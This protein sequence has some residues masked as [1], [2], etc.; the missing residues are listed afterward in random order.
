ME[1]ILI[2]DDDPRLRVMLGE[3]L[4][5]AGLA[6]HV[7]SDAEA[8]LRLAEE[9]GT[10]LV[11]LDVMMPKVDGL[12]VLRKLRA[13]P[14]TA[15]LPVILL[16]ARSQIGDKLAGLELGADDY[17][18]KPFD[19]AELLARIRAQLRLRRLRAEVEERNEELIRFAAA[20]A[21]EV[22]APLNELALQLDAAVADSTG[23]PKALEALA[24]GEAALRRTSDVLDA[25]LQVARAGHVPEP[26]ERVELGDALRDAEEQVRVAMGSPS[27]TPVVEG[28]TPSV[29]GN[30]T[31][32][33]ELFRNLLENSVKHGGHEV[34]VIVRFGRSE[35]GL[36][37]DV[38]DDGP[39]IPPSLLP[40]LF[41]PFRSGGGGS[42]LGL[43]IARRIARGH[44]GD[45]RHEP[46]P[47]GSRFRHTLPGA[48]S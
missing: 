10:S 16:T 21:H 40:A 19:P 14:A 39:G 3:Q 20:V 6:S 28:T 38:D 26:R 7:A 42:G 18:T 31:L 9:P 22:R 35:Q 45:L 33:R 25:H 30:P 43:A 12:A 5:L 8:A 32:L 1:R 47:R 23:R 2:V 46:L 44:G 48:H 36:E 34:R 37:I 11:L 24:R 29:S 4:E 13:G 17:V 15:R 41:E 27:F